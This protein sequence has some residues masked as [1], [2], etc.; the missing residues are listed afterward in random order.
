MS[1]AVCAAIAVFLALGRSS[2]S[3]CRR[4]FAVEPAPRRAAPPPTLIAMV[5]AVL[6]GLTLF[7]T[8]TGL[9]VGALAAPVAGRMVGRLESAAARRRTQALSSQ[10]PGAIDLLVAALD[11]GR[12]PGDAF[13]LVGR[14]SA[15]PLGSEFVA[16]AG[17]LSVS[18]DDSAVWGVLRADAVLAPLGRSFD[19]AGR[20]GMPVGRILERLSDE[21]RRERRASGQERARSVAVATTAPLGL[22]FLPAFFLIG[23][24]PTIYGTFMSF[25]W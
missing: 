25:Q 16:V 3:R 9:L 22:C 6:I 15:E 21:L 23:I 8:P 1:A 14:S 10:L 2:L 24:V 17:R 7:G 5:L 20:S 12:P 18:G 19:R 4:I 11:A 13:A